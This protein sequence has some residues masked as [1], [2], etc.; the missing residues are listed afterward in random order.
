M[1]GAG[2]ST[3]VRAD[4]V[5]SG[6]MSSNI[7][8]QNTVVLQGVSSDQ[9]QQIIEIL[10]NKSSLKLQGK[11]DVPWIVDTGA[12]NHVTSELSLLKNIK[13]IANNPILIPDGQ[14]VNA[15]QLG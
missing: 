3:S 10:N 15:N 2:S 13:K 4:A 14:T 12:N 6:G 11:T 7:P 1:N 8:T 5:Q 9:V